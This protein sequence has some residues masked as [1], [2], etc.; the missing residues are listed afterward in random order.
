MNRSAIETAYCFLH[1]KHR[2][3]VH[4]SLDWQR[5]DI[6]VIIGNFSSEMDPELYALLSGGDND[7][8]RS[9]S[10]FASDLSDAVDKLE[11]LLF[12]AF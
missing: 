11:R 4:S 10:R 3:Y 8:L 5:D 1:Q 7:Y 9:H 12:P 6:E 2:V